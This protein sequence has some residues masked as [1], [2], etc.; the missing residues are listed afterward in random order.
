LRQA[1]TQEVLPSA[2]RFKA[3]EH[4]R[5]ARPVRPAEMQLI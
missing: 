4:P 1:R 2:F 5:R 3:V